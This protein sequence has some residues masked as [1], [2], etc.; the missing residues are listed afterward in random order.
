M[1]LPPREAF[2]SSL[3]DTD[4]SEDDYLHAQRVWQAFEC[5]N[6]GDY[7]NLYLATD[8]HL[9]A[10]V[11]ETFRTTA[12]STYNLDPANYIT[13]PGKASE[14]VWLSVMM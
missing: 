9:L 4:I 13:L 6:L 1:Q 8:V 7:H 2:H 10:D 11:F 3:S 12:F 14:V 5:R